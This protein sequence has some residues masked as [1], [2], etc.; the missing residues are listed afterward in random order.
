VTARAALPSLQVRRLS[1]GEA[2]SPVAA[3]TLL[4]G[5]VYGAAAPDAPLT[6]VDAEPLAGVCKDGGPM[7][8]AW[9]SSAPSHAGRHGLVQWRHDGHWLWGSVTLP[10]QGDG[11]ASLAQRAYRE[12]FATLQQFEGL[13]LQRLWNYLPRINV[14]IDGLERYRQFNVGRQQAFLEAHCSAFEGAPAACALGTRGGPLRVSFLAG[15]GHPVAVENPRQV[16]AYHYP[17]DYGPRSPS[18]SRAALLDAGGGR[19]GLLISG[20]A[21][22]VGHRSMHAGD[23]QAQ[24]HEVLAN[25][26]AVIDA[27]HAHTDARFDIAGLECVVYVRRA[28]DLP[29]VRA[30]LQGAIGAQAAAL[31]HAVYLEA[32]ICRADLLVEIEAHAFAPGALAASRGKQADGPGVAS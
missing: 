1:I 12:I 24:T 4:G 21:S 7:V 32:A 26:Q 27:A 6:G 13:Q 20:T 18:F 5:L 16:S 15:R 10:E 14:E 25:L 22:I 2:G 3:A 19:V 9:C 11:I 30:V 29:A 8:D 23:V 31:R 28:A 17:R